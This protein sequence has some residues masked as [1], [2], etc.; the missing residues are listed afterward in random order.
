MRG[1][2]LLDV[3]VVV[4]DTRIVVW[5]IDAVVWKTGVDTGADV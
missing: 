2:V 3:G 5:L 1:V 4:S